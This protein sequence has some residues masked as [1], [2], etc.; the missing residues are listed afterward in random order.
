MAK[1]I[2]ITLVVLLTAL[3]AWMVLVWEPEDEGP[4]SHR[5]LDL[6]SPPAGGELTLTSVDGPVSLSD[7]R[8][9]VVLIYFGYTACPD[10]C[11]INLGYLAAALNR[12]ADDEREDVQVLFVSVDPERDTPERVAEY[13]AFFAP[14]MIGLT[15][16]AEDIAIA[17]KRYGAAYSRVELPESAMGYLV[18]HSAYTY[19]VDREGR[20]AATLEHAT[21]PEETAAAIRSQLP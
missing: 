14:D 1:A 11:P 19:I 7:F 3:L 12:L 18:D 8:G 4:D 9:K 2:P 13:A 5:I 10:V 16:S 21:P 17:A 20:L 15:G 6:A